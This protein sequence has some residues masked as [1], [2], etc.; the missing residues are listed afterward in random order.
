MLKLII[1]FILS[2]SGL[3]VAAFGYGHALH[4]IYNTSFNEAVIVG[5]GGILIGLIL[6][7]IITESFFRI[8]AME[9]KQRRENESR[10]KA[11][12]RFD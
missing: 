9:Y 11:Y 8:Q 3:L 2:I 7:L 4:V 1:W 5:F 10:Q 12:T 6:M